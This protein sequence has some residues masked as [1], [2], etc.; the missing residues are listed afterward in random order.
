MLVP[1]T[2]LVDFVGDC[3]GDFFGGGVQVSAN[4]PQIH[5]RP[6]AQ[7]LYIIDFACDCSA[8]YHQNLG[9]LFH[10]ALEYLL[11]GLTT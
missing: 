10:L 4:G 3:L 7:F 5:L 11:L 6:L 8:G 1:V 2:R 9:C